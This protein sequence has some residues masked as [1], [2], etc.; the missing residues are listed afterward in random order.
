LDTG[1]DLPDYALGL[2]EDQVKGYRDWFAD[3]G[4]GSP[5]VDS[6]GHGTHS[7]GLLMKV[8]PEAE[9]YVARV[10]KKKYDDNSSLET[11]KKKT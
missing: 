10:F 5:S 9:I 4:E 6:D 2:Y 7:A 3:G 11:I 8:A 1:I